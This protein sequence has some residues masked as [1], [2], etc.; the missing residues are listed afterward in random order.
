ML[1]FNYKNMNMSVFNH[2][3]T[4]TFAFCED[5]C[6]SIPVCNL[7]LFFLCCT[8]MPQLPGISGMGMD[9]KM[10]EFGDMKMPEFGDMKMPDLDASRAAAESKAVRLPG[11]CLCV[12]ACVCVCVCVCVCLRK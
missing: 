10:P 12:C 9:V 4:N 7:C 1:A 5:S 2:A 3:K 6:V 11:L 8:A